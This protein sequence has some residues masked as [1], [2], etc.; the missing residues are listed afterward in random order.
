[1]LSQAFVRPGSLDHRRSP[2]PEQG[3][4]KHEVVGPGRAVGE[5]E[6]RNHDREDPR[7]PLTGSDV[8]KALV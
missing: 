4:G 2:E 1:M 3:Y 7:P 5:D 8:Q 6:D